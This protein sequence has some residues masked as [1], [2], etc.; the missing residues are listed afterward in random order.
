VFGEKYQS[1]LETIGYSMLALST[2]GPLAKTFLNLSLE[3]VNQISL[4]KGN[5]SQLDYVDFIIETLPTDK[6]PGGDLA[7]DIVKDILKILVNMQADGKLKIEKNS[8]KLTEGTIQ[9]ILSTII[10]KYRL[11]LFA[12]FNNITEMEIVK[13]VTK[14][15]EIV[16]GV[17]TGTIFDTNG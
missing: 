14:M 7:K 8:D 1:V 3:F 11:S 9:L 4:S 5:L 13:V 12:N 10:R 2:G 15:I 17:A 6:L 16:F